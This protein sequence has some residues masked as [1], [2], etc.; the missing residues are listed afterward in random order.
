MQD[1]DSIR[2][3][4]RRALSPPDFASDRDSRRAQ[5][6]NAGLLLTIGV[7][8]VLIATNLSVGRAPIAVNVLLAATCAFALAM[9]VLLSWSHSR[10]VKSSRMVS[11]RGGLETA[12]YLLYATSVSDGYTAL[13]ERGRPDLTVEAMVLRTEWRSLFT[14]TERQTALKRLRDYGFAVP[15]SEGAV[16]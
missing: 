14:L 6:L 16:E 3:M 15:L 12:R 9:K 11:E 7:P 1:E 13:W 5:V 2:A 4:L 10:K 8:P